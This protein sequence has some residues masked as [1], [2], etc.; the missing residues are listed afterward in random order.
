M[1]DADDFDPVV[2]D[3]MEDRVVAAAHFAQAGSLGTKLG[4]TKR[5]IQERFD[6]FA[7]LGNIDSRLLVSPSCPCRGAYRA[8]L[9]G[10]SLAKYDGPH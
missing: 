4:K 5:I 2:G 9:G 6:P 3:Q 1:E 7:Q 8:K 10:R